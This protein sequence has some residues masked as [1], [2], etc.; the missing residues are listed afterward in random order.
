MACA[1]PFVRFIVTEACADQKAR[2]RE[3]AGI[4]K[5][6]LRGRRELE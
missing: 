3:N 5:A 1:V 6:G 4:K 2:A